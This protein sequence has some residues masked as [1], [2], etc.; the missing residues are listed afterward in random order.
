M[1]LR[2]FGMVGVMLL[3]MDPGR[4]Q[5]SLD[6]ERC[7]YAS[8]WK[9]T[10]AE[11]E[12]VL[13]DHRNWLGSVSLFADKGTRANLCNA[14][15]RGIDLHSAT[16]RG[17]KLNNANLTA[18]N[19]DSAN[20]QHAELSNANL[21][22]A[23]LNNAHLV[24]A[25]LENA[26]LVS[27]QLVGANLTLATLNNANLERAVLDRAKLGRAT[28]RN[29]ILTQVSLNKA[30]LTGADLRNAILWDASVTGAKLAYTNL[31]DAIYAPI[32]EPPD[33]YV[34]GIIGLSTVRFPADG[35]IGLLQ[36]RELLQKAGLRDLEGETTFAI[37]NG[38]SM[39]SA[40]GWDSEKAFRYM[41]F[42]LTT[43]YG[44]RPGR[45]LNMIATIWASL[46]P[47]Y[48]WPIWRSPERSSAAA[49]IFRIWPKDRLEVRE[50][51]P[52]L[53][54]E[55]RVER[56]H[57]RGLATL[58]WSAYFSLLSAFRIAFREFSV[59]TWLTRTQPRNF[60]LE[61]T[62]WVRTV[63]GIQSL[64]SVYLLALWL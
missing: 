58:G 50:D 52:T 56:L 55:A 22:G 9:P 42:G 21:G 63:A 32:S 16:L 31:T 19:L 17:V 35:E 6:Q 59:G 18:T 64:L 43:A 62:G 41:A 51:H 30:D 13:S 20:L 28:L 2:I 14:D 39:Y 47:L 7:P 24:G 48:A 5:V 40:N 11:L 46:I 38:R 44:L 10:R 26:S 4:A 3:L 23:R 54:D 34:S 49:G 57:A 27:A 37:E 1:K 12:H 53:D 45:A 15:L 33:P 29:A 8:G 36:L 60:L 61:A 25:S